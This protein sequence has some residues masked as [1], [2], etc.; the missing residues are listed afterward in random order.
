MLTCAN[1]PFPGNQDQ[2]TLW[3]YAISKQDII[4][5]FIRLILNPLK[6]NLVNI[7]ITTVSQTSTGFVEIHRSYCPLSCAGNVFSV[8][9]SHQLI[10]GRHQPTTSLSCGV[11]TK[12]YMLT[13]DLNEM[14]G[15]DRIIFPRLRH[16]ESPNKF[17]HRSVAVCH[18]YTC[19]LITK[20]IILLVLNVDA[21][22]LCCC[23]C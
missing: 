13:F 20:I 1:L 5:A 19:G 18:T 6:C 11:V 16:T 14:D 7:L 22:T 4:D 17:E 2:A 10:L 3:W 21:R 12:T 8:P 9:K 23:F 15:F